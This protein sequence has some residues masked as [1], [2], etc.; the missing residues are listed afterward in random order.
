LKDDPF[1]N[2]HEYK[3]EKSTHLSIETATKYL[4]N[5]IENDNIPL[6]DNTI[7][8]A[9][10][11]NNYALDMSTI[12]AEEIN[13]IETLR[14]LYFSK[15]IDEENTDED[16]FDSYIA[17]CESEYP[18]LN[19]YEI[20]EYD[21]NDIANGEWIADEFGLDVEKFKNTFDDWFDKNI[22]LLNKLELYNHYIPKKSSYIPRSDRVKS[23]ANQS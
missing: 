14:K 5:I 8:M 17:E 6:Y 1:L 21:Y 9:L 10:Q 12:S 15:F 20:T 4:S 2:Q 19:E 16:V 18:T 7:N 3:H 13:N 23:D 22:E 11:P